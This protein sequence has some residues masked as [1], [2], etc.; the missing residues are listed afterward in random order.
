MPPACLYGWAYQNPMSFRRCHHIL[1]PGTRD[2]S[3]NGHAWRAAAR[4]WLC[5]VH[6]MMPGRRQL[7]RPSPG[8]T[9]GTRLRRNLGAD[10]FALVCHAIHRTR[11]DH[12]ACSKERQTSGCKENLQA[13][14]F[15]SFKSKFA[16]NI[17]C[18]AGGRD[19]TNTSS[20]LLPATEP[21]NL[22]RSHCILTQRSGRL[23]N[24]CFD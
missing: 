9:I 21:V 10:R 2:N 4:C 7:L 3:P 18:V 8:P 15:G 23:F 17:V 13:D 1:K 24:W 12:Q 11:P 20:E 22:A 19:R 14:V 6:V 16:R 5:T